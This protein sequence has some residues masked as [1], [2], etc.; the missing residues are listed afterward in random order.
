MNSEVTLRKARAEDQGEIR[1]LVRQA[2]LNPLNLKW[3]RFIIAQNPAG[4]VIACAQIKPHRDGSQELASL[5]VSAGH[6]RQ[7]IAGMV[8]ERLIQDHDGDLYLM[9][10]ASLGDFYRKFG[11]EVPPR[12][13]L[14][15]FFRRI[16]RLASRFRR[17]RDPVHGLLIM[18]LENGEV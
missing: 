9:C 3:H 1:R 13:E 7:G 2:R 18:K 4:Q 10:R 15:G 5:V 16:S 17:G 11:F 8:V 14:P 12:E 6:R